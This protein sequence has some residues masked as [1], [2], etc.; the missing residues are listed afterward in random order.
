MSYRRLPLYVLIVMLLGSGCAKPGPAPQT[1]ATPTAEA[2]VDSAAAA[3]TRVTQPPTAARESPSTTR[4]PTSTVES[5]Q[6]TGAA[7]GAA[8]GRHPLAAATASPAALLTPTEPITAT[9]LPVSA[10]PSASVELT[11]SPVDVRTGDVVNVH[12]TSTGTGGAGWSA[13]LFLIPAGAT[14]GPLEHEWLDLPASGDVQFT[15]DGKERE[16]YR[17]LVQIFSTQGGGG[18][19]DEVMLRYPCPDSYFF[20][21]VQDDICPA[22]PPAFPQAAQQDFEGGRMIWLASTNLI[23]VL[24]DAPCPWGT[25]VRYPNPW[26][27]GEPESDPGITPPEGR[28]QPVRGFGKVWRDNAAV[29]EALGWP[30]AP[31]VGFTSETQTQFLTCSAHPAGCDGWPALEYV[32]LADARVIAMAN[33]IAHGMRPG[34][35]YV[36]P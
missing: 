8:A 6:T 21:A 2:P 4:T 31:E 12:W 33:G 30:L 27:A 10:T 16:R 1:P 24:C 29:R 36:T 9:G 26:S 11:V 5:A 25:L 23:Y 17:L 14:H 7:P 35:G 13:Q 20:G 32:R 18:A 28:T 34:W 3:T 22:G 19:S 15:A